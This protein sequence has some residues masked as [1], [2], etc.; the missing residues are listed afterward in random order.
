MR[1]HSHVHLDEC[2]YPH[3][4]I[5]ITCTACK[6]S[7]ARVRMGW[8]VLVPSARACRALCAT[9]IGCT[10]SSVRAVTECDVAKVVG[11]TRQRKNW[12]T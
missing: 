10:V 6:L 5:Q 3:W 8:E 1:G 2:M 9:R 4:L 11:V 12:T 7:E